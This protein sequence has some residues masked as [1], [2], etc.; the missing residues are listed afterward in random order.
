MPR[1][2]YVPPVKFRKWKV[3]V[4][5]QANAILEE[6]KEQGFILTLRQLYYKFVARDLFPDE[7]KDPKTGSKNNQK[8]YDKLG[9]VI[10][11]ARL[12]GLIDWNAIEDRTRALNG[13]SH[14]DSPES[15][16]RSAAYWFLRDKWKTQPVRVEVWVEKDA[17]KGIVGSVANDLDINY[18]SCRGYTSQSEMWVAAQRLLRYVNNGQKVL[19]LHLGDHD[20]SGVDMSRDIED[21]LAL[22]MGK[23]FLHLEFRRIALNMD[24]VRKYDPPSSP[25]KITDSRCGPYIELYGEES[26]ELDALE[27]AVIKQLI[28]SEVF[29]V[30][31]EEL[32]TAALAQEKAEKDNMETTSERWADVG[33]FLKFDEPAAAGEYAE[34]ALE[35]ANGYIDRFGNSEFFPP[36]KDEVITIASALEYMADNGAGVSDSEF[37]EDVINGY[38][39][40]IYSRME[41]FFKLENALE[42]I[43][44]RWDSLG[45]EDEET[46]ED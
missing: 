43:R 33:R 19:L 5:A 17:M 21:R 26:W 36:T 2:C 14:W 28:E 7:W 30:R 20:P 35:I 40:S 10:S 46:D 37:R 24:Q 3:E 23:K 22:F 4:I 13:N 38:S 9:V 34:W 27:P 39:R 45:D 15:A 31:D 12:A 29:A 25:A 16:I 8:S 18:F 42:L 44:R 41:G 32:W 1:I 6:Y 11:D